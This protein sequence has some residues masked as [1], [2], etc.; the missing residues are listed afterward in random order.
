MAAIGQIID[1]KYEIVAELGRGGMSV[2]Y[3]AMDRRL[4]KQWAIKEAKQKPGKDSNIY[5][6][7]PIAEANLLKSLDHPGIVRIV[8]IIEQDGYIYIVEDYLEGK[9]LN[10]EVKKGPSSPED[11]VKWGS[12]LCDILDYLHSRTPSII[13]RDMKPANVQLLPSRKT[14]KLMDFGIAKTYKPQNYSDTTNLGTRGYAAPEQFD[15]NQQSDPRTDVFSLGVTL[16]ALLMGKTPHQMEFYEDIRKY[17]PAVTDGL[18]KVINKATNQDRNKRYQNAAE[19]KEALIHYH[20]RDAA[21]IALRKKKLA[22]FRA[23]MIAGIACFLIGI[24]LIPV[25][26]AIRS[27]DYNEY[28]AKGDYEQ[29]IKINSSRYEAY[30]KYIYELAGQQNKQSFMLDFR[31][32]DVNYLNISNTEAKKKVATEI[33]FNYDVVNK[34]DAY[35]YKSG[36]DYATDLATNFGKNEDVAEAIKYDCNMQE[37]LDGCNGDIYKII[38]CVKLYY[39]KAGDKISES[40]DKAGATADFEPIKNNLAIIKDYLLQGEVRAKLDGLDSIVTESSLGSDSN[41]KS[42]YEY[43]VKS[44]VYFISSHKDAYRKLVDP[45]TIIDECID[46]NSAYYMNESAQIIKDISNDES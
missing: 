27:T 43:M 17:N 39:Y 36:R 33:I 15:K 9:S 1:G 26:Y 24:A 7:T 3:L 6:L 2:V 13:Y 31:G 38:G 18:V 8:D 45:N 21:V 46:K 44:Q 40:G 29:C 20:D 23:I 34:D 10:E 5:T 22:R 42:F 25:A 35:N 28:F 37:V 30:E 4:N 32:D 41:Y 12:Q 11:V 14:I 19:F 16:R